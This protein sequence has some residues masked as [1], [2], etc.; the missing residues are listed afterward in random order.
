MQSKK[1]RRDVKIEMADK[2]RKRT[3]S[4][5]KNVSEKIAML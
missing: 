5:L 2:G 4:V 3:K 1:S